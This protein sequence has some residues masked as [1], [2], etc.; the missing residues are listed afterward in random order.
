MTTD[1]FND[2]HAKFLKNYFIEKNTENLPFCFDYISYKKGTDNITESQQ[3]RL[4]LDL[5]ENGYE[6]VVIENE[7]VVKQ[8]ADELI[9]KYPNKITFL[10]EEQYVPQNVFRIEL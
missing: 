3:Y 1:N 2:E 9:D 7:C 6:V 10:Y 8:V 5:L 4:C